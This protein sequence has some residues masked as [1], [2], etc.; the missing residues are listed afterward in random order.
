M[1]AS[2]GRDYHSSENAGCMVIST[3]SLP[4]FSIDE[5]HVALIQYN[6][7]AFYSLAFNC[8]SP[9]KIMTD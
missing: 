1:V 3:L 7:V 9:T 5:S 4:R 6:A 2:K 8:W